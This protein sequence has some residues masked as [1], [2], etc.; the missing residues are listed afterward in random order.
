MYLIRN[1]LVYFNIRELLGWWINIF[2]CWKLMFVKIKKILCGFCWIDIVCFL[3]KS[4]LFVWNVLY[5][6]I[7]ILWMLIVGY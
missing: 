4:V 3:L 1:I 5:M 6:Y 7:S 2:F